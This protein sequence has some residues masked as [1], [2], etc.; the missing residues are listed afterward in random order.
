MTGETEFRPAIALTLGDPN[1]IGPEVVLKCVVD[2]V[3]RSLYTPVIV[4]NRAV[5]QA[6]SVRLG[7]GDLRF[8]TFGTSE[9]GRAHEGVLVADP[10]PEQVVRIRHGEVSAG[11][12]RSAMAAVERAV[13]LC[14]RRDVDAM[15]TAPISK[16]AIALAGYTDPGHTEFIARAT[17]ASEHAMMM[18]SNRLRVGLVTGHMPLSEVPGHITRQSVQN[19]IRMMDATLRADF[20]VETPNIAV[21]GLNP[22]AGDGG[23]LGTEDRDVIIPAIQAARGDGYRVSGPYPADGFFAARGH[24][25]VDAVLAMYHDQGLVPFKTIAF[26]SGVNYTA[27]LPIVRTS[28]DH[29]T[30][31]DIAGSG[32]ADPDSMLCAIR[33]AM[34]VAQRRGSL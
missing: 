10:D 27:G 7:L 15:V 32:R 20:G 33:L 23:V 34:Q 26:R 17:G 31:F 11:A 14:M 13:T 3:L 28:P 2:R 1:G 22:H 12:G 18:V 24:E 25:R 5:L 16:E 19:R 4:G 8:A 21:L 30:A 6:E 9:G 29:G